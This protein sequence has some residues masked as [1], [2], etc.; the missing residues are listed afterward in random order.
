MTGPEPP[1][2][3]ELAEVTRTFPG[4]PPVTAVSGASLAI[5]AAELV[6]I[7]GPSGSGKSTVLNIMG[8]LDPTTGVRKLFGVDTAGRSERDLVR[9]RATKLGFVF[10]AFHLVAYLNV[11]QNVM[12]PL[13]HQGWP[14][15]R[16]RHRALAALEQVGLDHL[17][18]ALP[19]TLS[20]GEKQRV[21]VA[22][23]VVHEP[24]LLLC[25]EPTGN[26]DAVSTAQVLDQLRRLVTGRRAVVVVT[27]DPEVKARADRI[28]PVADGHVG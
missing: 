21:A 9:L 26:L 23:A 2:L 6:A 25:D 14:P 24:E 8:L 5:R 3:L 22:R 17:A 1:P 27:H 11:V 7:V 15:R 4:P 28:I 16:R 10:Q 20:G 18:H 12:L 13:V 19:T